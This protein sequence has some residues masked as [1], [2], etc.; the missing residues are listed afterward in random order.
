MNSQE[1]IAQY[2]EK[3][4]KILITQKRRKSRENIKNEIKIEKNS[5]SKTEISNIRED[6]Y[7]I[8]TTKQSVI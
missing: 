8:I 4:N 3:Y 1:L 5:K 6:H 7:I 2:I